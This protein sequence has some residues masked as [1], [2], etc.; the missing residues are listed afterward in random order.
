[1][2]DLKLRGTAIQE[3]LGL[4]ILAHICLGEEEKKV[5]S[6]GLSSLFPQLLLCILP[7][8]DFSAF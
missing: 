4:Q 1:M 8:S 2:E 7:A 5:L 6:S 3:L